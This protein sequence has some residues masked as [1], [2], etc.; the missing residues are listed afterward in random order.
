MNLVQYLAGDEGSITL[1]LISPYDLCSLCR[2][3]KACQLITTPS[4]YHRIDLTFRII[5]PSGQVHSQQI[6]N[7]ADCARRQR[8]FC[9]T[10]H[11][12]PELAK[13]VYSISW[14]LSFPNLPIHVDPKWGVDSAT[15][16]AVWETFSLLT[17]VQSLHLRMHRDSGWKPLD[18]ASSDDDPPAILFPNAQSI[19]L[20]GYITTEF[21]MKIL[22]HNSSRIQRLDFDHLKVD[23]SPY[24][25]CPLY[26]GWS[27]L[28]QGALPSLKALTFRSIGA[29]SPGEPFNAAEEQEAFAEVAGALDIARASIQQVYIVSTT[30]DHGCLRYN[31]NPHLP[32]VS[33]RHFE[34]LVVP[35]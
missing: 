31:W 19:R 7:Y 21:A 18:S 14:T 16:R 4:L 11:Q 27:G 9:E 30:A 32:S 28:V 22:S 26:L 17:R 3:N 24:Y 6:D 8:I 29:R 5:R 25:K 2:V 35:M 10:I 33:E 15:P 20:H 12:R 1:P 34:E 13:W 23:G